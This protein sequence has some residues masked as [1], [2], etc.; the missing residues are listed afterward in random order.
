[1][2]K[3]FEILEAVAKV[4]GVTVDDMFA[5]WQEYK[6]GLHVEDPEAEA[7]LV[8]VYRG[9]DVFGFDLVDFHIRNAGIPITNFQ[10]DSIDFDPDDDDVVAIMKYALLGPAFKAETGW[11]FVTVNSIGRVAAYTDGTHG[12]DANELREHGNVLF[13][14]AF[15]SYDDVQLKDAKVYGIESTTPGKHKLVP[16]IGPPLGLAEWDPANIEV[17]I[18]HGATTE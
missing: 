7:E 3:L 14:A 12:V 6:A 9:K 5:S 13:T 11:R 2:E 17:D 18:Y 16:I 1:M 4:I 10:V 8:P 15:D